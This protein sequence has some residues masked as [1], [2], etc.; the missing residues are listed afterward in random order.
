MS[1]SVT[2]ITTPTTAVSD[3]SSMVTFDSNGNKIDESVSA[4]IF[5][6]GC[7][8]SCRTCV[9]STQTSSCTSCYSVVSIS[10]NIYYDSTANQ[11]YQQ[12]PDGK[13]ENTV[14]LTNICS[15]CDSNCYKCD[16]SAVYCTACV[17]T[18]TFKYLYLNTSV[19][20]N[21]QTCI[22]ACPLYTYGDINNYNICTPCVSPCLAC[23]SATNCTTCINGKFLFNHTCIASCP[24]GT[25]IQNSVT[26][27]CDPCDS[28]CLTC[29]IL[30]TNCTSC[31]AS[32]LLY[33]GQCRVSC[34]APLVPHNGTCASCDPNCQTCVNDIYTCTA[35]DTASTYPYLHNSKCL[36][37]CP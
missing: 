3:Y 34:P 29:S 11:C 26:N 37:T 14:S 2:G 33:L 4:I 31:N 13:Y 25:A 20:P 27:T 16:T 24:T 8:L 30:T 12:C 10:P 6:I 15:L 19:V 32:L 17:S 1:F 9:S 23:S 36:S 35:C 5:G 28:N 22:A 7:V 18:S 21:T